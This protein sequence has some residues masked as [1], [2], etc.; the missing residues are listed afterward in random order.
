[1]RP[2]VGARPVS[3][4]V[5]APDAV[6]YPRGMPEDV[7]VTP[8]DTYVIGVAG[9]T[10]S[11]KTTVAER[12]VE[13][14]GPERVALVRLDSYYADQPE[15][16]MAERAA[17]NYDHP[18]AFDW[19]LL[20]DHVL[21]LRRGLGVDVPR[22]DFT[23]YRRVDEVDPIPPAQVLVLEGILVLYPPEL[24]ALMR[25]KVF[26]DTDPD[27]RFIRRLQRDVAERGRT[28]E[29]VMAQYLDTVRPMHLQFCEPTKRY[30]DV[31]MP[32]GG[33][34]DPAFEMLEAR[35]RQLLR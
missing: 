33:R 3:I 10:G 13:R 17:V 7:A 24:R 23:A 9:G 1:M 32:H 21:R 26:V 30:A 5:E 20:L 12:L 34:N 4:T 29:S 27:V 8:A 22:Y 35:V 15:L 18:D 19:P 2:Q 14:V 25:L 31:I 16:S 28:P 11:G 6:L